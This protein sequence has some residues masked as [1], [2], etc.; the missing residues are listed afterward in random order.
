MAA[1]N[2]LAQRELAER[3]DEIDK[4]AVRIR[5][6]E[7]ALL[8]SAECNGAVGQLEQELHRAKLREEE[9]TQVRAIS[10]FILNP[11]VLLAD[12]KSWLATL[13]NLTRSFQPYVK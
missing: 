4:L 6:L 2:Q 11:G 5:E 1:A 13:L 7:Q 8:S 3:N 9:L 12:L 10:I